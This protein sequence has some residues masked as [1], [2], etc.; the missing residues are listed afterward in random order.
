MYSILYNT[1]I[2]MYIALD[3]STMQGGEGNNQDNKIPSQYMF[4]LVGIDSLL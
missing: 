3:I 4:P 2:D 1:Y